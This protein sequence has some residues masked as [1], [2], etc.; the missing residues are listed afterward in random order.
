MEI[1]EYFY[2]HYLLSRRAKGLQTPIF[3]VADINE[4]ESP[5]SWW[6]EY[7]WSLLGEDLILS[8]SYARELWYV[9]YI[10]SNAVKLGLDQ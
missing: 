3:F 6:H 5:K 9:Q 10:W 8:A 7:F 4:G 1:I 2:I